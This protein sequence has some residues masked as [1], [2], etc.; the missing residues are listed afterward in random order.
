MPPKLS[1]EYVI[2]DGV[3][4]IP[5]TAIDYNGL[6][7]ITIPASV[8]TIA[9]LNF[10][11]L[12]LLT[13]VT[14]NW[15]N[16]STCTTS[17]QSF[18]ADQSKIILHVPIG[19]KALY[20]AHSLWGSGFMAITSDTGTMDD[21]FI[22][23]DLAALQKVG[24]NTDG[25]TLAA[26]YR[27]KA[28]IDLSS[29]TNWTSIGASLRF[30]GSY[31][32]GG[33][34]ISNLKFNAA[35]NDRGLFGRIGDGAYVKNIKL[36]NV[37]VSG[38]T[39]VGAVVGYVITSNS[40]VENCSVAGGSVTATSQS[41]GGVVGENNGTVKNCYSTATVTSVGY[42]GGVV[43]H[44]GGV[45]ENCYSTGAVTDYPTSAS[46]C[47]GGIAGGGAGTIRNSVAINPNV[48]SVTT[49]NNNVGK[50][51]GYNT[52]T[53]NLQSNFANHDM[54]VQHS[55]NGSSGTNKS[56]S[57]GTET[58][59]GSGVS[60]TLTGG[61]GTDT[62]WTDPRWKTDEGASAWDFSETGPWTWNSTLSLPVLK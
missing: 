13:D 7:K 18:Q 27:Q 51:L 40:T 4:N 35:E 25:W 14:V 32:G 5:Q 47:A 16:P 59:D 10:A 44:N 22:V 11:G 56:I 3:V 15:A 9:N 23:R 2:P 57:S 52:G 61:L 38:S 37:A 50:V 34:T 30:T 60:L 17:S 20:E 43:G 24:S 31:D 26:N 28:D 19:T 58:S 55:W 42:A 21:P 62:W 49:N 46:S 48:R 54:I 36:T 41:A 29:I 12:G 45:V 39:S 1:G 33:Y 53:S 6:T 8:T